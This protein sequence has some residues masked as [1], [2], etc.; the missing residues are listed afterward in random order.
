MNINVEFIFREI[1]NG[2]EFEVCQ[3]VNDVFNEFV[4]PTYSTEGVKEFTK[5]IDP[6][7]I[8]DRMKHGNFIFVCL[9]NRTIIGAIEIR[10]N[11][12][13]ALL[14]VKSQYHKLGI[15]K[16]LLKLAIEKCRQEEGTID[17]IDVHSSPNAV[18]IYEKLG[19]RK[20]NTEQVVNGIRFTPMVLKLN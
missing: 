13:L 18:P 7:L 14:F 11:N 15:A 2:E 20:T 4:A 19:F 9:Y 12:H 3:L 17:T 5:Y 16:K 6:D 8:R 10:S 1:R